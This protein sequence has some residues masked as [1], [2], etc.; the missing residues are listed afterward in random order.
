M[1]GSWPW[2]RLSNFRLSI[3]LSGLE[4]AVPRFRALSPL[5]CAVTKKGGGRG[6][7][8]KLTS[9]ALSGNLR[10]SPLAA[11][12][13]VTLFVVAAYKAA[14]FVI[15]DDMTGLSLVAMAFV[16]CALVVAILNEWRRGLYLFIT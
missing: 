1:S 4:C 9:Q 10:R 11:L 7:D 16:V 5:E 2:L 3:P 6:P 14:G 8:V 13:F 12:G 15:A